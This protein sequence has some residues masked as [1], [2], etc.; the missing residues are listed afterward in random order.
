MIEYYS[1]YSPFITQYIEFKRSLGYEFKCEYVFTPFDRFLIENNITNIGLTRKDCEL[2]ATKRPNEA[3][4][5]RYKRINDIR[6]FSIFLN[7]IGYSSYVARKSIHYKTTFVPYIFTK[8][9]IKLFF[10]AC[11]SLELT[12]NSQTTHI[13]PAIF[14]LIYGCGL[15]ANEALLIK[16]GDIN[17]IEKYIII[18]KSKNGEDRM[19]PISSTLV[20]VLNLYKSIYRINADETDIFFVKKNGDKCS[21][22]TMYEWFRKI[23][24][25]AGISHGGRGKGPRVHDFRHSFSVHSLAKMSDEDLDL[26]YCLPLLSKYLGHKSLEAT[27]KYVRLTA[28]MYP[29][30][31]TNVNKLCSYVFPEVELS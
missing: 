27:D 24:R 15:R 19:L 9:E 3:D 17:L 7:N 29:N 26:Y 31:I 12:R 14:R 1:E 2:W 30:I 23:L 22:D 16:C 11:D 4:V 18:R 8:D 28:D 20:D 5:T 13:Y 6:N 21:C 25:K 10:N